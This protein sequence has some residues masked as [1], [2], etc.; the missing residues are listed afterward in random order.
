MD[1]EKFGK[2]FAELRK[3]KNLTQQDIAQKLNITNKAVSK[4]ERGLSFPDISMLKPISEFFNVSILELLNGERNKTQEI[5]IDSRVL[6][7]LKQVEHEKNRK[8]R[9]VIIT[10]IIFVIVILGLYMGISWSKMELK[11]YNPIRAAIGYIRVAKFNEAYV[12]VGNIPTKTIYANSDFSIEEYMKNL[13]YRKIEGLAAKAGIDDF[14]TNGTEKILIEKFNRKGIYI[15]QFG[16]PSEYN[17]EKNAPLKVPKGNTTYNNIE[18][19]F[20]YIQDI[21]EPSNVI[22]DIIH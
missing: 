5:D 12:E 9:K 6:T 7:I 21:S 1:N 16:K 17:D 11:T 3:E 8:I 14:Y 13:G 22:N 2:F 18:D 15:Y 4:W 10:S 19:P 20:I